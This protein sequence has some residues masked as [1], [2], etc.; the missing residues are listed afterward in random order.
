V[1]HRPLVILDGPLQM[2]VLIQ[3]GRHRSAHLGSQREGSMLLHARSFSSALHLRQAGGDCRWF[4]CFVSG[5]DAVVLEAQDSSLC[6]STTHAN[7]V[8]SSRVESSRVESIIR[9][10]ASHC[11]SC[12]LNNI[13]TF[14][15]LL[16]LAC[17]SGAPCISFFVACINKFGS[18][19]NKPIQ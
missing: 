10:G 6:S 8:E 2:Y 16:A 13:A 11:G 14:V 3:R 5:C 19:G 15:C 17:R 18:F 4:S 7:R 12:L 9:H 1:T